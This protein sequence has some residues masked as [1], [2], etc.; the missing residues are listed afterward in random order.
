MLFRSPS[1][2]VSSVSEKGRGLACSHSHCL[3]TSVSVLDTTHRCTIR[4][5]TVLS[6]LSDKQMSSFY[7]NT[8]SQTDIFWLLSGIVHRV[9]SGCHTNKQPNSLKATYKQWLPYFLLPVIWLDTK[10]F[11]ETKVFGDSGC[12]VIVKER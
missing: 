4:N 11:W 2:L 1:E 10:R 3:S 6:S 9:N 7:N 5:I 8:S 12:V